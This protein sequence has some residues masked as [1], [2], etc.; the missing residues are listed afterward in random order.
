MKEFLD[1]NVACEI[2]NEQRLRMCGPL[3][4]TLQGDIRLLAQ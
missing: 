2:V 1:V 4:V 3:L